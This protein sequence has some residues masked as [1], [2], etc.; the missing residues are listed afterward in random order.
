[1]N[2]ELRNPFFRACSAWSRLVCRSWLLQMMVGV[3]LGEDQGPYPVYGDDG[4]HDPSTMIKDGSNY[5]IFT[6][7]GGNKYS[8]DLRNWAAGSPAFPYGPPAWVKTAVPD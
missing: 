4:A 3:C 7:G 2:S 5:W 8:T 1:M 6:T